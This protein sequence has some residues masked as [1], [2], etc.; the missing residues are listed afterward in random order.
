MFINL[1]QTNEDRILLN[2]KDIIGIVEEGDITTV[3]VRSWNDSLKVLETYDE[4]IF[5]INASVQ[6]VW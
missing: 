5:R 6:K 2:V 1:T 4:I 3:I